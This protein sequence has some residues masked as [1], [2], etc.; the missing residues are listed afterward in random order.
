MMI[1]SEPKII[2]REPYLVVGAYCTYEG[3]DEGPGWAGASETFFARKEAI[4]NRK[5]DAVLGFLYHPH[6]DHPDVPESVQACFV[7]VDVTDF[8]HIPEGLTTTQ[9]SGGKYA[10]V[11]SQG[12]TEA[13]AAMGVGDAV[14]FLETWTVENGYAEGDACFSCSYENTPK[15]PFIE[16]VYMKIEKQGI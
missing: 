14:Q 10:I 15:P 9:F 1:L 6:K 13:E 12:D 4:N 11:A 3:D 16:Y 2:E 8:D 7:G 5:D